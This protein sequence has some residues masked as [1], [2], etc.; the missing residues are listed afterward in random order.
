MK[1]TYPPWTES[2]DLEALRN[3][4]GSPL[5]LVDHNQLT[6]NLRTLTVFTESTEQVLYP[7]K[8]NPSPAV[9]HL[10]ATAGAGADCASPQEVD[11][12]L[13]AGIPYRHIV[14]NAPFQEKDYCLR[15]LAEGATVVLDDPAAIR[16]VATVAGELPGKTWLRINPVLDTSYERSDKNQELMAH[17][18]ASS[19]FGVPEENI[20]GL[21]AASQIRFD[22]LHLHVGTQMD[23]LQTFRN[24]LAKLHRWAGQL[25]AWGHPVKD[26]DIGGGLGIAF[27]PGQSFP[28]LSDWADT[29]RPLRVEGYRY[30]TEP[31]HAL[32]GNAVS[33]LVTLLTKKDSRQRSWGIVDAGTDQLAKV[34]LLHWPHTV[35]DKHHR[36]LPFDGDDALAGPLCFAGDTLLPHT[37]L[38]DISPGDPLLVTNAGAYTFA[39]SNNFNGRTMPAWVVLQ[40][41]HAS[42][43]THPEQP[44]NRIFL[45]QHRWG[46]VPP[47]TP[48]PALPDIPTPPLQSGYLSRDIR[49]DQYSFS[50]FRQV[51]DRHYRFS[52]DIQSA[53][54]FVSMPLAIRVMGDAAIVATLHTMEQ[55]YKDV[56]VWGKKLEME[57]KGRINSREPLEADLF[58]SA[59]AKDAKGHARLCAYFETTDGKLTGALVV[60]L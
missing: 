56:P 44:Y 54:P 47:L 35:L 36:P 14:F 50:Y 21:L 6:E 11:L 16:A 49:H 55:P 18:G 7:V 10:L 57:Y 27:A 32:V 12:A 2:L 58:L 1:I 37:D 22:G 29:L 39:L 3:Q 40:G 8:A 4:F 59:V 52:A 31:G 30:F 43:H 38:S 26:L 23:N 42:L 24:A 48:H 9:L 45:Q 53:V 25:R 5:W 15:L 60:Y 17:G 19:K 33:L 34:T 28:S 51:G 20:A 46:F 13:L 41:S